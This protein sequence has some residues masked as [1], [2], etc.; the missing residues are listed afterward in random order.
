MQN[1]HDFRIHVDL[2]DFISG[3]VKNPCQDN[4]SGFGDVDL[5]HGRKWW[6]KSVFH[7]QQTESCI[8]F[9]ISHGPYWLQGVEAGI[10]STKE[11]PSVRFLWDAARETSMESLPDTFIEKAG[12]SSI[13]D[14]LRILR[15]HGSLTESEYPFELAKIPGTAVTQLAPD[16]LYSI[17]SRRKIASYVNLLDTNGPNMSLNFANWNW[18]L[19]NVGPVVIRHQFY[20]EY[21]NMNQG[22]TWVTVPTRSTESYIH[23]MAIVGDVGGQFILRNS[24]GPNWGT[25]G[26]SGHVLAGHNFMENHMNIIE[27]YGL[28]IL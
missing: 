22:G 8:A 16:I 27:A 13:K 12:I 20:R 26:Q 17:M 3:N 21:Q 9:A 7:Q 10:F 19:N 11:M 28:L 4:K 18:W 14:G 6:T 24:Y 23:A 5:R 2:Q 25:K 15:K 1:I